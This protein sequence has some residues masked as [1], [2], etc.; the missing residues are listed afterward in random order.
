M[1][2]EGRQELIGGIEKLQRCYEWY[3]RRVLRHSTVEQRLKT[4]KQMVSKVFQD[5][6]WRASLGSYFLKPSHF[7]NNN[8]QVF[9]LLMDNFHKESPKIE[10]KEQD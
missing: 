2:E 1:S 4:M 7:N 5:V 9:E 3:L 10:I 8:A 6:K